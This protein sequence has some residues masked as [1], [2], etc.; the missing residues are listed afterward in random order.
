LEC[1]P[2]VKKVAHPCSRLYE[3]GASTMLMSIVEFRKIIPE[4]RLPKKPVMVNLTSACDQQLSTIGLY[5]LK[6]TIGSKSIIH[7]VYVTENKTPAILGIDTIKAFGL[8][9]SLSK[10]CFTFETKKLF[11]DSC[12]FPKFS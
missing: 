1:G 6:L 5:D 12:H 11:A 9:H 8:L 10:N 3:T 4:N 2:R 7:P